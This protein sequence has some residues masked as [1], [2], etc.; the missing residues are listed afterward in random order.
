MK[1]QAHGEDM[2]KTQAHDEDMMKTQAHVVAVSLTG[3]TAMHRNVANVATPVTFHLITKSLDVTKPTAGV[4]L[5]VVAVVAHILSLVT[6]PGHRSLVST[7]ITEH[8]LVSSSTP[9][10]AAAT[11]TINA[12]TATTINAAAATTINA[13][14]TTINAATTT[15]NAAAATT[16]LTSSGKYFRHLPQR[17]LLRGICGKYFRHMPQMPQLAEASAAAE[18]ELPQDARVSHC[19]VATNLRRMQ[20]QRL[21]PSKEER[22]FLGIN[23][24]TGSKAKKK[25][26]VINPHVS[27][28][29]RKLLDFEWMSL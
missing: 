19:C 15:I 13:A 10:A 1:T 9:A 20:N 27:T 3:F 7:P 2:M 26:G 5:P 4:A 28:F 16:T 17:P 23:P 6:V 14:T 18:R 11:T 29:F 12:A 8:F 24:E 21:P 25:R 22:C